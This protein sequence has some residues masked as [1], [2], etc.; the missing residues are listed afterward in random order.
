MC[1][2]FLKFNKIILFELKYVYEYMYFLFGNLFDFVV[3]M[4]KK[5]YL[6]VFIFN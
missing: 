6:I 4:V 1:I 2:F 5:I 3:N